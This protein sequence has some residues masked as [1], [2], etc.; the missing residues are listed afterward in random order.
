MPAELR[1]SG[2]SPE[3]PG[4]DGFALALVVLLL[5]AI[6]VAGATGF[7]VVQ[8]ET[9]SA[10]AAQ[11]STL[12]LQVADAGLRRYLG[13]VPDH[14]SSTVIPVNEG[15][16][17]VRVHQ[18]ANLDP[19]NHL[20]LVTS[21]GTYED[22]V[23][24]VE[25]RRVLRRYA[26][27]RLAPFNTIGGF[28]TPSEDVRLEGVRIDGFDNAGSG[29]CPEAGTEDVAGVAGGGNIQYGV[30]L[31]LSDPLGLFGGDVTGDPPARSYGSSQ[32][33]LDALDVRWDLLTD[34]TLPVDYDNASSSGNWPNFNA[35]HP[36]TFP[37]IRVN[38]N[39]QATPARSG[40]G[41]LIV[42]G[43]IRLQTNF[44]WKGVIVAGGFPVETR[45]Q[46]FEIEGVLVVGVDPVP[47][48]IDIVDNGEILYNS[49]HV[50]AA[51]AVVSYLAPL[52]N[53]WWEAF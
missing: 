28:A 47:S 15:I 17:V 24:G 42:T 27:H 34:P 13:G 18:V 14:E 20:D 41:M 9:R 52:A 40:R 1:G 45:G 38:G 44:E 25:Y 35:I 37:L 50:A 53:T 7:F 4:Q 51:G 39:L 16:A 22:L 21:V 29:A 10:M 11:N 43:L 19:P 46:A 3:G 12:A 30:P 48:R 2:S 33:L 8:M 32:A 49:C 31:P 23:S 6:G 36:D 26:V 5:F